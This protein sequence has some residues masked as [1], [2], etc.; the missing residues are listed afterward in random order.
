RRRLR[1]PPAGARPEAEGRVRPGVG[2][3]APPEG[4]H[5]RLR[6]EAATDRGE[7]PAPARSVGRR[8]RRARPCADDRV[9][10]AAVPPHPRERR[11]VGQ[12]LHG[13]DERHAVEGALSRARPPPPPRGPRLLRPSPPRGPRGPGGHGGQGRPPR[14][15]LLLLLVPRKATP[16]EAA[17]RRPP[18]EAA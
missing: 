8:A 2:R 18:A 5:E 7:P 1:P 14:L 3:R 16:G 10:P 9:L 17:P 6:G 12:G 13:V 4:H 15:L 11:V